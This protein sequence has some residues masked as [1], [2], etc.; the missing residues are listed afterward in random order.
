VS[1]L[2]LGIKNKDKMITQLIDVIKKHKQEFPADVV[3]QS[4]TTSST[5]IP[6]TNEVN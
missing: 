2:E 5:D 1:L 4:G 6:Q 3:Q